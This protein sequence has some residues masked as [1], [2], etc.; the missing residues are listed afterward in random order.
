M[1]IVKG[2]KKEQRCPLEETIN[3][4][5]KWSGEPVRPGRHSRQTGPPSRKERTVAS[6][7]WEKMPTHIQNIKLKIIVNKS[8]QN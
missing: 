7:F 5:R 2:N 6:L 4:Q 3:S 8:E 1:V